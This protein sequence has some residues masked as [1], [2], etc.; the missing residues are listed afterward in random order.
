MAKLNLQQPYSSL[1]YHMIWCSRR[2]LLLSVL[3]TVVLLTVF[4][5]CLHTF[6]KLCLFFSKRYT[7]IQEL[8]TQNAKCFTS[9]AKWSTAFNIWQTHL[10]STFANTF[11][12]I[13]S[14]YFLCYIENC[15]LC[16]AKSVLWNW[17]LSQRPRISVWFCRFGVWFWCLSVRFQKLCVTSKDFVCKHLKKKKKYFGGNHDSFQDFLRTLWWIESSKEQHLYLNFF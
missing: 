14:C 2:K 10:E 13:Y 6:S 7:Q 17:K 4:F 8:H 1:Q 5:S 12:I 15:V 9:L 16:F 11:A 3:K